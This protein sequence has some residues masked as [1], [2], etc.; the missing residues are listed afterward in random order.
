MFLGVLGRW[1]SIPD[2]AIVCACRVYAED[3]ERR[4]ES[5]SCIALRPAGFSPH[6]PPHLCEDISAKAIVFAIDFVSDFVKE[7]GKIRTPP[8]RSA[9]SGR[10][11]MDRTP[12]S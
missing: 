11:T 5:L 1:R 6:N 4:F 8:G 7:I 9:A 12:R 3:F 2:H 10:K